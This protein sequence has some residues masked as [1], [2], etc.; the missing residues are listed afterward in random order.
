VRLER[1]H[2]DTTIY[3][4]DA[5]PH[6]RDN[7]AAEFIHHLETGDPLHPTLEMDFNLEVM[8]ILDAGV[9]SAANGQLET[10][11]NTTWCIG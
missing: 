5:L 6:G 4:A 2:G 7:I 8:A 9:R 3:E 10:V 1:G 11:D